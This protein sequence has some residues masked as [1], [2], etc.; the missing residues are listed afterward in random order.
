MSSLCIRV[1]AA[2]LCFELLA[3]CGRSEPEPQREV[4]QVGGWK[5]ESRT[6]S[7][8]WGVVP[9]APEMERAETPAA[10]DARFIRDM[11]PHHEQAL[12]MSRQA[13]SHNDLEER[14]KAAAT[15]IRDDQRNEITIMASWLDAWGDELPAEDPD[16]D[17]TA[18]PGMV[19]ERQIRALGDL[20]TAEAEV[21]FLTL[22][23]QHHQGAVQMSQDYLGNA[24]NSYTLSNARHVIRE[25]QQE[26]AY[27]RTIIN[28]L[29]ATDTVAGCPQS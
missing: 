9:M 8:P 4:V 10:A 27:M 29:C 5:A 26:I 19:P 17:H 18:M 24:V 14:V 13:L 22:M 12:R 23:V 7:R 28:D 20:A 2:L 3:G 6:V 21:A 16:H 25:Q 1:L 15:F 11:I